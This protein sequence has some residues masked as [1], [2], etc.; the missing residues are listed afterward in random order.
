MDYRYLSSNFS[1]PLTRVT[2]EY[3]PRWGPSA[4][5][6]APRSALLHAPC[7]FGSC[8]VYFAVGCICARLRAILTHDIART[9]LFGLEC[10][11]L[12]LSI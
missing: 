9:I 3:Y 8:I 2:V 4:R 10:C 12:L 6:Y 11:G 5:L 7:Y 1:G